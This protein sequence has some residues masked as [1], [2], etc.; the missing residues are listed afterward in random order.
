MAADAMFFQ[1]TPEIREDVIGKLRGLETELRRSGVRRLSL[2]GSIAKGEGDSS[3]VDLAVEIDPDSAPPDLRAL[4]R[5]L[6]DVLAY[7]ADVVVEPVADDYLRA[8]IER[9]RIRIF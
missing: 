1:S 4:E 8:K 7:K 9:H 2:Y 5:R 6:G 3:D